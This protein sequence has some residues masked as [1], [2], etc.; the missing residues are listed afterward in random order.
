MTKTSYDLPTP[1]H[2][3]KL[4]LDIIGI[5]VSSGEHGYLDGNT[6]V[7][8]DFADEESG[9]DVISVNLPQTHLWTDDFWLDNNMAFKENDWLN[10]LLDEGYFA[11]GEDEYEEPRPWGKVSWRGIKINFDKFIKV[12]AN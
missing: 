8:I 5:T 12:E 7:V 4:N 2:S 3:K 10:Y 6:V 9:Y 11:Y 1:F